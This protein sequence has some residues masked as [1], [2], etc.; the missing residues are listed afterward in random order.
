MATEPFDRIYPKSYGEIGAGQGVCRVESEWNLPDYKEAAER[1]LRL[2]ADPVITGKTVYVKGQELICDVEGEVCFQALYQPEGAGGEESVSSFSA[3]ESFFYTFRLPVPDDRETDPDLILALCE[4]VPENVNARLLGPRRLWAKCD[5]T[6]TLSLRGNREIPCYSDA[7]P[8]DVECKMDSR[9]VTVLKGV[10][11]QDLEVREVFTLP[12]AYLPIREMTDLHY[13][14]FADRVRVSDGALGFNGHLTVNAAYVPE[15]ESGVISFCQPL[16]FEKSV[17]T[18][19]A[20]EGDLCEVTLSPSSMRFSVELREGGENKDLALEILY[21]AE[22]RLFRRETVRFIT[23]LYSVKDEV[24]VSRETQTLQV[25]TAIR[26]Y[27]R[28]VNAELPLKHAPFVR[29]EDVRGAIRFMDAVREGRK[30]L[31]RGEVRLKYL[32][33]SDT[34]A[35]SS[36]E[37]TLEIRFDLPDQPDLPEPEGNVELWGGVSDA[38][39]SLRDDVI[40]VRLEVY[41]RVGLSRPETVS[42]VTD[43]VRKGA[44]PELKS[45]LL[46]Y[47]PD[48]SESFWDVCR[49]CRARVSDVRRENQWEGEAPPSVVRIQYK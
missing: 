5:L 28:D 44:L 9:E 24:D 45:G 29:A 40:D 1:L 48:E 19:L 49:K 21:S 33:V 43:V 31:I 38:Q 34:G 30:L 32:T 12:A 8:G 14:L 47:Y 2:D 46:F 27:I 23:D 15:G 18:A 10:L 41:G 37:D 6:L 20:A 36:S 16:E 17:G 4:A 22:I 3:K 42:P 25:Y 39:L 11:K 26:D 7:V 13:S 35:V